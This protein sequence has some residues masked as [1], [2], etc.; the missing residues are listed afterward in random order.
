M[1]KRIDTALPVAGPKV[2]RNG[3]GRIPAAPWAVLRSQDSFVTTSPQAAAPSPWRKV[4]PP[5]GR[6]KLG[7][8]LAGSVLISLVETASILLLLPL[9]ALLAGDPDSEGTIGVLWRLLGEPSRNAFAVILLL[10]VLGGFVAKDAFTMGFRWWMSGYQNR[11]TVDLSTRVFTYHLHA[12]YLMHLKRGVPDMMR[13]VNDS[14]GQFF[15]RRVGGGMAAA[16][17][18]VTIVTI[19]AALALAMPWE[20]LGAVIYFGLA[21][22]LFLRVVRPV[23][24]QSAQ[25]GL[26]AGRE[27]FAAALEGFG[28]IKD[29]KLGH[30]QP[31]F[32]ERFRKA[33]TDSAQASRVS[34][35][36][37][38][39]PKYLL[40]I[41]LIVGLGALIGFTIASGAQAALFGKLAVL[42]AAAFRIL[43]SL[44]RFLASIAIWRSGSPAQDIL[45]AELR[46]EDDLP[47][48][49]GRHISSKLM[50]FTDSITID[51][52]RFRY[53]DGDNDVLDGI[54]LSIPTGTSVGLVGGSGAG[55]TTLVNIL[56]GLIK[57]TEGSIESDG[58]NVFSRLDEWQNN[59][60]MVPQ[61]VFLTDASLRENIA[62][63][64]PRAE[65][66]EY[67]VRDAVSRSQLADLVASLPNGLDTHIG[68]R[69]ARLSGGQRQ[70]VG[71]ARALYLQ[72]RL[73]ILD[74]ATSALDNETEFKITQTIT[75]LHGRI[76]IIVIAHRLSTVRDLDR[77]VLMADGQVED[78]GTFSDLVRRNEHFARLVSLGTLEPMNE[79]P[80]RVGGREP[81]AFEA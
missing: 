6:L 4:F 10:A 11:L 60:A 35:Y 81:E 20:T 24:K 33:S 70:R 17:E 79:A 74:E 9:M 16:T 14:V 25:G 77:I 49:A 19:A 47:L 52:L 65:I 29:I 78:S 15:G 18:V 58:V 32:V 43:P 62:F 76:T 44:T 36:V 66:D 2:A 27:S 80:T 37:S 28:G 69:G 75:A 73:L 63:A 56:L 23:M 1:T 21:G 54:T 72:P 31:F 57:P 8:G 13:S 3:S 45:F 55:K 68:E 39:L 5:G 40:E 30:T 46:S 51:N 12:P 64:V 59:I 61:D 48:S 50:P 71:I 41:L 7:A 53:P 34:N 42:G 22:V 67:R 26:D 38:E